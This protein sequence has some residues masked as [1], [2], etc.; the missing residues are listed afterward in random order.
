M[1]EAETEFPFEIIYMMLTDYHTLIRE[2]C[3]LSLITIIKK[4]T[5]V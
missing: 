4:T 1:L 3:Y 2:L 5:P